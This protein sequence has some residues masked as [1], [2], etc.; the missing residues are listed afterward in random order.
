MRELTGSSRPARS[1]APAPGRQTLVMLEAQREDEARQVPA[2]REPSIDA[3]LREPERLGGL[4]QSR[5]SQV[6]GFDFSGVAIRRDS[7]AATGSTRAVV[8]D[9]EIHFREGAYQPDTRAG[10]WLIAHELA[11]VVQQQGGRGDRPASRQAIEREADRAASLAV[12]GRAAPIALRAQPAVAYAF[13]DAEDHEEA[14]V[15]ARTFGRPA[16]PGTSRPRS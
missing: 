14:A 4:Q 7:P 1:A 5:M 12:L 9:G 8:K 2:P 3:S 13:S 6:F 10:D 15:E 16:R 11:H